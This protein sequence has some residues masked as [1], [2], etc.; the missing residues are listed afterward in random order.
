MR[1]RWVSE[2]AVVQADYIRWAFGTTGREH[3]IYGYIRQRGA[4]SWSRDRMSICL[5]LA[6]LAI[7]MC[8]YW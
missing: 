5:H 4:P 8:V 7:G 2:V 3:I 1:K 6:G